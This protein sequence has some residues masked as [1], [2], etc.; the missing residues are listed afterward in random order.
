MADVIASFADFPHNFLR[1]SR[2]EMML[3]AAWKVPIENN[4]L[5]HFE[6]W[7]GALLHLFDL[8]RLDLL[9]RRLAEGTHLSMVVF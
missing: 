5:A 7:R 1:S 9:D 2:R 8:V 6:W 4:S 3:S